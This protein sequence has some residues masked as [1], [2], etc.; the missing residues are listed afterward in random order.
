MK[1]V[2]LKPDGKIF[3]STSPVDMRKSINGLAAIVQN[4]FDLDLFDN[5]LFVFVNRAKDKVKILHWDQDGFILF[6][7]RFFRRMTTVS[8]AGSSGMPFSTSTS[9]SFNARGSS[10]PK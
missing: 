4:D 7:L 6:P 8:M 3:F 5:A 2:L 10:S 9:A 1:R